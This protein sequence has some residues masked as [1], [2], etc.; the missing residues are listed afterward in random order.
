MQSNVSNPWLKQGHLSTY[1]FI[2]RV[3]MRLIMIFSVVGAW[4]T[5]WT[6]IGGYVEIKSIIGMLMK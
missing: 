4:H 3:Y 5:K 2:T 1:G 6:L